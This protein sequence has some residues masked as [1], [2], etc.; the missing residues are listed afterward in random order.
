MDSC[1][2][3]HSS[4]AIQNDEKIARQYA[5]I[6]WPAGGK[7]HSVMKR[8]LSV[9]SAVLLISVVSVYGEALSEQQDEAQLLVT[10]EGGASAVAEEKEAVYLGVRDYGAPGIDKDHKD[11]FQYRFLIDGEENVFFLDNGKKNGNGEYE[12][13][14]QNALKDPGTYF[15]FSSEAAGKF[16]WDVSGKEGLLSDQDHLRKMDPEQLL[17]RLFS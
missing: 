11:S 7:E 9:L 4:Q 1:N 16:S 5:G 14:L 3:F 12:Y 10:G 17:E 15:S 13:P 2:W 8:L 6:V